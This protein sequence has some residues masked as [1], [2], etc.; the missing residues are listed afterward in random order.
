L[1]TYKVIKFRKN[2]YQLELKK[3]EKNFRMGWQV[4]QGLDWADGCKQAKADN[5][6]NLEIN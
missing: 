4:Y 6:T 3:S 2:W 5:V 1:K